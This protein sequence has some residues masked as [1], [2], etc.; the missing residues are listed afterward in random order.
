MEMVGNKVVVANSRFSARSF[1]ESLLRGRGGEHNL[2]KSRRQRALEIV[3]RYMNV[4][5][6]GMKSQHSEFS[7][8]LNLFI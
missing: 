3:R 6:N 1:N 4:S 8:G 5:L 2:Q 7:T